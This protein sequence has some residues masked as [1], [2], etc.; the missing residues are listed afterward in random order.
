VSL[1]PSQTMCVIRSNLGR[2][3]EAHSIQT[4]QILNTTLDA[5][6]RY[7][8]SKVW[9]EIFGTLSDMLMYTVYCS[10][11]TPLLHIETRIV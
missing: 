10:R 4:A 11:E 7:I 8:A 3:E 9:S 6:S 2:D 5:T 1:E